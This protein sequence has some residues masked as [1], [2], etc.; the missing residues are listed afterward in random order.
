MAG[1]KIAQHG[2]SI[3][4][5]ANV[6]IMFVMHSRN[7][8]AQVLPSKQYPGDI[9]DRFMSILN[10]KGEDNK[11]MLKCYVISLFIPAITKPVLILHGEQGAAK[12]ALEEL[13]RSVVDPSSAATLTFP[14]TIEEL[15]QQLSHNYLAYYDNVSTISD[16]ISDQLCRAVTGSGFSKREL[17]SN[18]SDII[19]NFKRAIGFNGI[20]LVASKVKGS[21]NRM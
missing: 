12:T 9:L 19:Y 1:V 2:W 18:D 8:I 17:Y 3:E 7:Q 16:W 13:I 5:S 4:E 10:V 6:P 20:N 21:R 11:L 14:G 15:I